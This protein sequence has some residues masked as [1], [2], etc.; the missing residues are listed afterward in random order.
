MKTRLC[1]LVLCLL[2]LL[3]VHF[4]A[5][6]DAVWIEAPDAIESQMPFEIK[7]HIEDPSVI[8]YVDKVFVSTNG[9]GIQYAQ[10]GNDVFQ[11]YEVNYEGE[12]EITFIAHGS[13]SDSYDDN[14]INFTIL[15]DSNWVT[16]EKDFDL[17][18]LQG[19]TRI[20]QVSKLIEVL[21]IKGSGTF[22][23]YEDCVR[24]DDYIQLF[25]S[26]SFSC[27]YKG[28]DKHPRVW[29]AG[30]NVVRHACVDVKYQKEN[31]LIGCSY[32]KESEL[33]TTQENYGSIVEISSRTWGVPFVGEG[34]SEGYMR[35]S[36][37]FNE[38]RKYTP[39]DKDDPVL[40]QVIYFVDFYQKSGM[41]DYSGSVHKTMWIEKDEVESEKKQLVSEAEEFVSSVVFSKQGGLDSSKDYKSHYKSYL[42]GKLQD[43]ELY[44]YGYLKNKDGDPLPYMHV[45]IFFDNQKK[46][47]GYT[48]LNGNYEIE[49][50]DLRMKENDEINATIVFYFDYYKDEK[51]YYRLYYYNSDEQ[52][53]KEAYMHQKIVITP[54]ENIELNL[55]ITGGRNIGLKCSMPSSHVSMR[56]YATIYYRMHEAVEFATER[57]H[58]NLDHKLPV[59][60]FIGN[61]DGNTLY[62]PENSIILI[63]KSDESYS[64]SNNPRNREYHEFGHHVMYDIYGSWTG[65]AGMQGVVNHDGFIN[66]TSA[67]S[68]DE[69]FAEFYALATAKYLGYKDADIY[70]GFGSLED[71]YRPWDARGQLEEFAVASLLWDMIDSNN[72]PGDSLTMSIDD[73]WRVI[74]VKQADVLG[75][76]NAFV[77]R[78][79][80]KSK[81]FEELFKLHGFFYDTRVGNKEYDIYE[82]LRD[83]NNNGRYDE[84]EV[85]VDLSASLKN[86]TY[87][88]KFK[89]NITYEEGFKI[90]KATNY[91]RPT[92]S[93]AVRVDGSYIKVPLDGPRF[94]KITVDYE[95]SSRE[96]YSYVVEMMDGLVYMHPRPDAVMATITVEPETKDY[97]YKEVYSISNTQLLKHIYSNEGAQHFAEPDFK[98]VKLSTTL[99]PV[100]TEDGFEP[101]FTNDIG[102]NEDR[103]FEIASDNLFSSSKKKTS[104]NN[105]DFPW[106]NLL[107]GVV[108]LAFIYVYVKKPVVKKQTNSILRQIYE[109]LR[110]AFVWFRKTVVPFLIRASKWLYVQLMILYRLVFKHS[111]VLYHKAVPH[112]KKARGQVKEKVQ[113]AKE[114]MPGINGSKASKASK[115]SKGK[116]S[117]TASRGKK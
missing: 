31:N 45:A 51:N 23:N 82:P 87:D 26:A 20:G 49:L 76:Y 99:D 30:R 25:G 91:A 13:Y 67:D 89:L 106:F 34:S 14:T 16:L 29:S 85:F 78:F 41:I 68:F 54:D 69:G 93:Q 84:G 83:A 47:E 59:E 103:E 116:R 2:L 114:G 38:N 104:K 27:D 52:R 58:Q 107:V 37:N 117:R 115:A 53:Y 109:K 42:P 4:V 98:L 88:E 62:S 113:K 95:D 43:T 86:V 24:K 44:V 48:D 64:S 101:S 77:K 21:P 70:A 79:P 66:P 10:K 80:E 9:G 39:K 12:N 17:T 97:T 63:A 28:D 108:L 18:E 46:Y 40:Y 75:Y 55:A 71:N 22:P 92:R 105:G 50:K 57:L 3:Q 1:I 72:E 102:K 19:N 100:Y 111:K 60:V 112:I 7:V 5:A 81:D 32:Q 61:L 73:V 74:A 6:K 65:D 15:F 56:D 36:T 90:G 94:Y 96:D 110:F 8:K 33:G 35:L 11:T